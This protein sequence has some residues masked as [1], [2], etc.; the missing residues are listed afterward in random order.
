[1]PALI[2]AC[3]DGSND[4]FTPEPPSPPVEQK[5][6]TVFNFDGNYIRVG[7]DKLFEI[8]YQYSGGEL[9]KATVN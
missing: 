3:G 6:N 2:T 7:A 4:P 8:W 5:E 9:W 1:M